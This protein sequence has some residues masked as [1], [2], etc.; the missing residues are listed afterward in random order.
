MNE[1]L[2]ELRKCLNMTQREFA[3][4]IGIKGNTIATYESGRNTPID[5]VISLICLKFDVNEE[6]LRYG[7]GEMFIELDEEDYL[8]QWVGRVLKDQSGSFRKSFLSAM[9]TWTDEDWAWIEK[10]ARTIIEHTEK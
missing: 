6:W 3:D 10:Q 9:S 1:R 7:T 5:A 4:I 2:K 8:M